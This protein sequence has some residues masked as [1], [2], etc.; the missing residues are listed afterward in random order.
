[1]KTAE[2]PVY[3][4]ANQGSGNSGFESLSQCQPQTLSPT[5]TSVRE[6]CA[7]CYMHVKGAFMQNEPKVRRETGKE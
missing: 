5:L 7:W 3:A 6:A 4:S 1:M 2:V